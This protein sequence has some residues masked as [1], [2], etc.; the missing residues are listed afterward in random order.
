MV[1]LAETGPILVAL[2]VDGSWDGAGLNGG[3]IDTF[4]PNSVRGGHAVAVVGYRTDGR[5]I[6]R[7]SWGT[8]WGDKGFGYVSPAYI[9]DSFFPESYG[10]TL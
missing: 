5:C 7:N 1:G 8:T 4:D 10:V 9:A 2:L 3:K 6:V